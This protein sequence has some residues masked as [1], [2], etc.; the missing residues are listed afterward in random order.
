[1]LGVAKAEDA[2]TPVIDLGEEEVSISITVKWNL[3]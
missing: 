2:S 1:M 3:N